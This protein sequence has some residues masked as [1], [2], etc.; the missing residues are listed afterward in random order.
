MKPTQ[1]QVIAWARKAGLEPHR[2]HGGL[3]V[4]HSNG[5]WVNI[6]GIVGQICAAV[7]E[8]GRKDENEACAKVCELIAIN[9]ADTRAAECAVGMTDKQ[10]NAMR[11]DELM[12]ATIF[13]REA[14]DE[15]AK[16]AAAELRRLHEVNAELVE[17]L[18]YCKQKIEYMTTHG[19]WYS[20]GRAIEK[21]EAALAKA[22]GE[23]NEQAY[24][25]AV[26]R[27]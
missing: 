6:E 2:I 3:V 22:T 24:T 11:L 10:S 8:A 7:Y 18:K 1:E 25:G 5:S 26:G 17:A 27:L 13:F 20:P 16:E 12:D 19:E 9:A 21:A 4:T 23:N 14:E 15:L